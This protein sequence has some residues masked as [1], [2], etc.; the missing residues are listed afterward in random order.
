MKYLIYKTTNNINGKIYI[1]AHKTKNI[2][3]GYM[4]SGEVLRKA[5]NKYGK[6]NFSRTIIQIFNT[7]EE[8]FDMEAILVTND[9]VL[10][11]NN[12]NLKVGGLGG[13]D[14][15]NKNNLAY[16]FTEHDIKK[17]KAKNKN[18]VTVRT[19]EGHK[20]IT[21]EEYNNG[22]FEH[23]TQGMVSVVKDGKTTQ[24]SK[25]EF[26]NSDEY[27]G[28]ATG[29]VAVT[30][31]ETGE[32]KRIPTTLYHQDKTLYL[33]GGVS[34]KDNHKTKHIKIFDNNDNLIGETEG[35]F[36]NYC[37]ELNLSH[38][39]LQKSYQTNTK[40]DSKNARKKENKEIDGWYATIIKD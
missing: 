34:G 13:W 12:Y 10:D 2:N 7:S 24:I 22:N 37:K 19:K 8:M 40:I 15:I 21:S 9:F 20:K 38:Y 26:D 14:Y 5:F 6:S 1:G 23:N 32:S 33:M 39:L 4:G 29:T 35:N 17:V 31:K 36:L 11:H 18:M 25:K 3:D 30:I 16:Q 28:V 27:K